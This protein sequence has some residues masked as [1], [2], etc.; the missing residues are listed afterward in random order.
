MSATPTTAPL[1]TSCYCGTCPDCAGTLARPAVA[2]PLAF[3]HGAIKQRMLDRI[4]STQ[5]DGK[6]PLD[7]LGTREDDDPSIALIDA[8]AGSL[9]ILAWNAARLSD[10]GSLRRTEDRDAL[11]D[12][13]RLVGYEPRP[14]L[15][16]TTTLSFTLADIEGAPKVARVPKG[17]KVASVPGQDEKPQIFE[18]EADFTAR[19]DWNALQ[20][21]S[22]Q[23]VPP[24]DANTTSITIAGA[25]TAIK[26]GDLLLVY[27]EPQANNQNWLCARVRAVVREPALDP[28]RT[29]IDLGATVTLPATLDQQKGSGFSNTV[30]VLGQR[31]AAFGA[32]APDIRLMPDAIKTAYGTPASASATEWKDLKMPGS[33]IVDLDAVYPDAITGRFVLFSRSEV[34]FM[35]NEIG[36]VASVTECSRSEFGLSAKLT[37]IHVEGVQMF[38]ASG[39]QNKVRQTAIY[40]ET[41]RE[42]LLVL[43][44][45]VQLPAPDT[46]RV[47]IRG[48]VDLPIGRRIVL[49][50]EEWETGK[51]IGEVATLKSSSA[52][53][54]DTLLVFEQPVVNHFHSTTLKLFANSVAASHGET[55][56]S[57]A[58]LIGSGIAAVA[59]PRFQLKNA[60]LAHVPAINPRG[61]APAIE[62]RVGD[63]LYAEK[64]TIFGL[65]SEDRA[66]TVKTGRDGK[67]A[68]QFAGRLPG[69]THNISALY[70]V[71]G[72]TAGNLPPGR[73]ATPMTPIIGVASVSNPVAAE[74]ASDAETVEDMRTA[75]PQS[76]RTLDRVVSLADFEA[77]ARGYRGIGKAVATELRV[78]MGAVVCLTI[79]TTSLTSPGSDSVKSLRDALALVMPPG[80]IVRIEGFVDL[81]ARATIAM[82]TDPALQRPQVEAAVRAKLATAF[83]R[84]ARNFGEALHRSAVL[85]AVQSVEGVIA[86]RLDA[87]F[88]Q[89]GPSQTADGR[90]LCPGP[91]FVNGVFSPARLLSVDPGGVQFVEMMP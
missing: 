23:T 3:R 63:R 33:G 46:D 7:D 41:G 31:A 89:E 17:T 66:Y 61:Y 52:A 85:A 29:R 82:V 64:P 42:T 25:A 75:A 10:D 71:G 35:V 83:G 69:G 73:I 8:F 22:P 57:G 51:A 88:I 28:P 47:T 77:F 59:S 32:T 90:L 20:A 39:F 34:V 48:S 13:T 50:G 2:D 62:V 40:I 45:D 78:G 36:R 70:R 44:E 38:T 72:G 79:A 12:L 26:V 4:G 67:A 76:I 15:A 53:N 43:D 91:T 5:I 74:G 84:A 60:P 37:Q 24:V 56:A 19:A 30:I 65:G 58:E 68:V 87:F 11:V 49:A 86:A 27:L 21:V 1:A 18:T 6:R 9:H 16:A 81:A 55:P 80:R 14:A 54:G